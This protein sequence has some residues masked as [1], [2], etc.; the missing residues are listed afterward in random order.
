MTEK[1]KE[2]MAKDI[3]DAFIVLNSSAV[4]G[5]MEWDVSKFQALVAVYIESWCMQNGFDLAEFIARF[6]VGMISIHS[7][8]EE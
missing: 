8:K 3:A 1:E 2:K 5:T 4:K 6:I 7:E